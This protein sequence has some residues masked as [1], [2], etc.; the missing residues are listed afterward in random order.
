MAID[1]VGRAGSSYGSSAF[2]AGQTQALQDQF[3]QIFLTQLR[4]QDPMEPLKEQEFLTQ[5]AQFSSASQIGELN[6]T[7]TQAL[8]WMMVSQANQNLLSAARLIGSTFKAVVDNEIVDGVIES[9]CFDGGL[10]MVKSGDSLIPIENLVYIGARPEPAAEE[11]VVPPP[12]A[13][14]GCE[15]EVDGSQGS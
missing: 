6:N 8:H 7:V 1:G 2:G 3:M 12:E 9:V 15:V 4:Y 14:P 11:E 10:I 5:M 13:N